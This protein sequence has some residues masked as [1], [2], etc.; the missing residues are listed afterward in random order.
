MFYTIFDKVYTNHS[1]INNKFYLLLKK[2]NLNQ[3]GIHQ[4]R[5]TFASLKLSYGEQLNW[6]SFMLRHDS[7]SFTQKVYYK[8]I[9]RKKEKRVVFDIEYNSKNEQI[10]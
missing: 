4:T 1:S 10:V 7:P 5:H 3:R 8:Y 6:V 2:L 9:P